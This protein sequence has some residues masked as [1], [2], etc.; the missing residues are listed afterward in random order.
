MADRFTWTYGVSE[1]TTIFINDNN[2]PNP[3]ERGIAGIVCHQIGN[4][5]AERLAKLWVVADSMFAL[6]EKAL[7][8][9]EAEALNREEGGSLRDGEPVMGWYFT[10]MRQLANTIQAEIAKAK[11]DT[12][13]DAEL[14]PHGYGF[15][16]YCEDCN[17][18][19]IKAKWR[20]KEDSH[21]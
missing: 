7:P 11:G 3:K 19:E 1:G 18:K 13:I 9:I 12:V 16:E 15:V 6:L 17:Q 14:C 4:E 2:L 21:G 10:E 5:E 8:I 20:E